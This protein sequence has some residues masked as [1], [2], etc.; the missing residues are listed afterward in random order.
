MIRKLLLVTAVFALA[1]HAAYP[2]SPAADSARR[3]KTGEA[4]PLA[5]GLTLR[6]SKPTKSPFSDVKLKGTPLVVVLELEAGKK[7]ATLSYNLSADPKVSGLYLAGAAQRIAPLAVIEDF[8]SWGTDNDK[9]VEILDVADKSGSVV[10]DF[11]RKGTISLLFDVPA[12]QARSPQ[13]FSMRIR[14]LK[15]AEEQHSFIVDL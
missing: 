3:L 8:P 12:E 6:V 13:K 2:Q 7:G 5:D 15:P 11:E 9:E 10:I 4:V 14:T 1:V